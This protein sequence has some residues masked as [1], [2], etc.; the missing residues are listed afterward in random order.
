MPFE[1]NI[2]F[3]ECATIGD[4]E[5]AV[6]EALKRILDGNVQGK[7]SND[8]GAFQFTVDGEEERCSAGTMATFHYPAEQCD[9]VGTCEVDGE[10]YCDKHAKLAAGPDPDEAYDRMRDERD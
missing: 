4:V 3:F 2:E 8:T 10:W 9:E 1:G 5:L 6:R 7:D